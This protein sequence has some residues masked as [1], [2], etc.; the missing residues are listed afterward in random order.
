MQPR[1]GLVQ[2]HFERRRSWTKQY[3]LDQYTTQ[4]PHFEGIWRLRTALGARSGTSEPFLPGVDALDSRPTGDEHTQVGR[5][6][7]GE[8]MECA[9][10]GWSGRVRMAG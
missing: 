10:E 9:Q 6:S 8:A 4:W 7:R 2:S 3:G 5:M 1:T